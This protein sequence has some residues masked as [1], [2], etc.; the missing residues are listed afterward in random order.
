ML[1]LISSWN[2]IYIVTEKQQVPFLKTITEEEREGEKTYVG[3]GSAR[4]KTKTERE[5][6][7]NS[8]HYQFQ[9]QTSIGLYSEVVRYFIRENL[10]EPE[11]DKRK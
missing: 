8:N 3:G 7:K 6:N 11:G 2:N 9:P 4:E 10:Q 1:R 5:E